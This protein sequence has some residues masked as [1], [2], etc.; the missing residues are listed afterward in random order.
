[1]GL[2]VNEKSK[3]WFK[4]A[5]IFLSLAIVFFIIFRTFG[6]LSFIKTNLPEARTYIAGIF[7]ITS[8]V[9]TFTGLVSLLFA[10]IQFMR[11]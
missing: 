5:I 11:K 1:M 7:F 2:N 10:V 9:F 4:K 3:K 6:N 8:G